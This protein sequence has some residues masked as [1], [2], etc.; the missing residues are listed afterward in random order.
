M[1]KRVEQDLD[2]HAQSL[3]Y[4]FLVHAPEEHRPMQRLT[5]PQELHRMERREVG[6]FDR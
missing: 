1:L 2:N 6:T 3:Q 4:L 5:V